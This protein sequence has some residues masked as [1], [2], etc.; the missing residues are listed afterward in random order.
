[1]RRIMKREEQISHN[2][3]MQE[4]EQLEKMATSITLLFLTV[5]GII[6]N[7]I[8]SRIVKND[9]MSIGIM[10]ALGYSN[11]SI[12][13]HYAKFSM[14]IGLV[15]STIGIILSIP[16][17][18][19]FTSLFI[20]YFNVPMFKM[21]VYYIYFVYGIL[22]TII[23]CVLSGLIGARN[24]VKIL[25]ADSM[26]P[27]AP[28]AGGRIWLE[29][30][31]SIWNRIS[32]SWKIVIR[33]ILRSKRRAAF[34][35]LGIALT[36]GITM[37]PMFAF[38]VWD[39]LFTLQ[40][41]EFQRM[42]YSVDFAMPMNHGTIR[43]LTQIVDVEHIE[44][45]VEIPFELRSG[46][47]KKA[48][49]IIGIPR[50]TKLYNF[51]NLS[52]IEI[53]LPDDGIFL[54]Q[55]LA[56]NL[57]VSVGD[58]IIIKNFMPNKDE[59]PIKVKGIVEQYLGSNGYID[60]DMMNNILGEGQMVTGAILKSKDDVIGK[61]QNIKN[62]RQVQSVQDMKDSMLQYIDMIIFSVGIMMIFG[63]ILGFAIVYNVTIIS[64]SERSM[65]FSSLRVM[66]FDKREIYK[67]I[68]RENG[69][70]TLIGVILGVPVG[71]GMCR[72]LVSSLSADLYS[73]PLILEPSTY[74]ITGIATIIF[75]AIAQLATA[76]KI[77]NLNFL[78]ALKNR[79]S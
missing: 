3:M 14:L 55:I 1:V 72:G 73:I 36:Y 21:E 41:G 61:L 32:F 51:K 47:K 37:V 23:F 60:I 11:L 49:N 53:K 12:L 34:L 20:Q 45:K 69:I 28:K 24:V 57:G 30:V 75:V 67:L 39:N 68:S 15:G 70:M 17:S 79:I 46:W 50:D 16:L 66:G 25:P 43:E 4:V 18:G 63:A 27:E 40:Y 42:D 35:I 48:V 64:I 8:L 65:E 26:R 62:I 29:K 33:N 6:I 78:D 38:S 22:L 77:Y 9:R 10:K 44:P 76:R 54:S 2:V 7:I 52:G 5:A 59:E 71:Y 31:K 13:L 19:A 74:I 58:E 56:D